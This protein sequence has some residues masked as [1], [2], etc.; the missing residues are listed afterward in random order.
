[1]P[2]MPPHLYTHIHTHTTHACGWPGWDIFPLLLSLTA[3]ICFTPFWA[4]EWLAL[5]APHIPHSLLKSLSIP[6]LGWTDRQEQASHTFFISL[7]PRYYNRNWNMVK[8]A[9]RLALADE[10]KRRKRQTGWSAGGSSNQSL[11]VC[12][13]TVGFYKRTASF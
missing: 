9:V 5:S 12:N 6:S 4:F 1:M 8:M 13:T 3:F 11:T 7:S 10:T 2:C